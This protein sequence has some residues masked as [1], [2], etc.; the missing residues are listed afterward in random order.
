MPRW[1]QCS[2]KTR[3]L[4]P[5]PCNSHK[6]AT[7]AGPTASQDL[8]LPSQLLPIASAGSWQSGP[9]STPTRSLEAFPT[10]TSRPRAGAREVTRRGTTTWCAETSTTAASTRRSCGLMDQTQRMTPEQSELIATPT[11]TL[12]ALTETLQTSTTTTTRR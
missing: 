2:R 10:A 11:A 6:T 8:L 3:K 9:T 12:H 7:S 1:T 4:L 5:V